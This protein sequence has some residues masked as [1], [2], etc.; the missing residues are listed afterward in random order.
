MASRFLLACFI[1]ANSFLVFLTMAANAPAPSPLNSGE[2][3]MAG[4]QAPASYDQELKID[5]EEAAGLDSTHQKGGEH[6]SMNQ[7]G[8]NETGDQEPKLTEGSASQANRRLGKHHWT[9]K[10]KSITG[11]GVIL[12]GFATTFLVSVFCYIRATKRRYL[13]KTT[14]L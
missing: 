4:A 13:D 14:P 10:S 12:G 3:T 9:D 11:G 5:V 7:Q 2:T 6:V 8:L 1:L